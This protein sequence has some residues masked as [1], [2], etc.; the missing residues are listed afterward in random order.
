MSANLNEVDFA[1]GAAF[2]EAS[3]MRVSFS[4]LNRLHAGEKFPVIYKQLD[5]GQMQRMSLTPAEGQ[6][7]A[8]VLARMFRD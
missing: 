4:N 3:R 6:W 5:D 8:D 7:L 1:R 2:T